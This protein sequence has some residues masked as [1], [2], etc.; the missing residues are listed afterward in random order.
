MKHLVLASTSPYRK[1]LLDKLGITY[2][3]AVPDIDENPV[4]GEIPEELVCRLAAQKTDAVSDR[5]PV[6]LIIGS[7]Q[8]AVLNDTILAKP[9]N[10]TNA[11]QQLSDMSGHTVTFYT[12]L[13]LLNSETGNRQISCE[14]YKVVFRE[15]NLR[16]IESYLTKE[17]PYDCA[18]SFKS[19]GLGISL[20]KKL[21]G[22]DPN[23]LIGLPLIK[24]IDMLAAEDYSVL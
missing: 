21:E 15:L 4:D 1:S 14:T 24:L 8:V 6:A 19:E 23:S 22:D 3:I 16:E 9:G 13:C 7:D 10:Y 18:G 12:G 11:L 17:Q 20:F 2:E 5:H